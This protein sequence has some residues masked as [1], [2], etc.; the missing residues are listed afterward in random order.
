ML[1][2]EIFED[3][4]LGE[5]DVRHLD[6]DVHVPVRWIIPSFP[7]IAATRGHGPIASYGE[8]PDLIEE[9]TKVCRAFHREVTD[10]TVASDAPVY[11]FWQAR[12]TGDWIVTQ[13]VASPYAGNPRG[14]LDYHCLIFDSHTFHV[15][16]YNPF[17]THS[18]N[19][20]AQLRSH[21]LAG[22]TDVF[23][24]SIPRR[25]VPTS[26]PERE[27]SSLPGNANGIPGL[28][29]GLPA[30]AN[31]RTL[32]TYCYRWTSDPTPPPSFATFWGSDT[33]APDCFDLVLRGPET[34]PVAL[35]NAKKSL[36]R[37]VSQL[38]EA[39]AHVAP[40]ADAAIAGLVNCVR[41]DIQEAQYCSNK[42]LCLPARGLKATAK[43]PSLSHACEMAELPPGADCANLEA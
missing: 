28:S 5:T 35:L 27:D 4:D 29:S 37:F 24:C 30:D 33:A 19:L 6:D 9:V 14:T 36:D 13:I 34:V 43:W 18:L 3:E 42:A 22:R 26:M 38:K 15:L 39:V 2:N 23:R 21:V 25:Y 20:Y 17:R 1:E 16:R 7:A 8:S 10:D 12:S 40:P 31:L 32:E 11:L 41:S